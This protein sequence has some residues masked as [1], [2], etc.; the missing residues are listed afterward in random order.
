MN[1]FFRFSEHKVFPFIHLS[2]K[3]W[4]PLLAL[5][6][7]NTLAKAQGGSTGRISGRI[8]D[9]LSGEAV[10][11]GSVGLLIQETNKVVNGTTS[12]DKGIF[13]LG[14]IPY[15]IY[16][17]NIDFIG[18]QPFAKNNIV[19]NAATPN[20]VLGDLRLKS[21]ATLKTVTITTEHSL[22]ENKIDKMVY[23]ADKDLTAQGGVATDLLKK[24]PQIS[25]DVDGN[26]ELQGN[27]NITFLIDGKPSTV[28]GNNVAD[29]LA[30]IPSS[31][32][33]AIE[34]VTSPGAK[35]DA[36]GTGGIINIVLKKSDIQ[37][38]N[39][40]LSLS[41][42]TRLENGSFNL[43]ARKGKFGAH[44]YISGNAQLLST[45]PNSMNRLS[46]DSGLQSSRLIQNGSSDFMR[47]GVQSGLSFDWAINKKNNLTASMSYNFNNTSNTGTTNRQSLLFDGAG[48][49][50]SNTTDIIG[51]NSTFHQ[52]VYDYSLSYK[53]KF[54]KEGQELELLYNSSYGNSFNYYKQLQSHQPL[55]DL[56]NGSYGNN[57]SLTSQ[58]NIALNYTQPL[59]SNL[60]LE[61]GLKTVIDQINS[62]SDV[63]LLNT[64][65]GNYD[66]SSSQSSSV[67][68]NRNVYAAYAS[69]T[70]KLFKY[71]DLKAGCR[72]EYT[73]SK[74][75][76]ANV[77]N[78]NLNPYGTVV[79]SAIIAHNFN[80]N[81]SLKLGYSYRI[82]R[83]NYRDLNPFM[84]ASDPKNITTGNPAL[85][86]ETTNKIELTYSK[87]YEKGTNF[88]IVL[89]AR[90]NSNDIQSYTRYYTTYKIG[91]ST[92]SNVAITNR[93]NIGHE[94]N[95]GAN[96]FVSVPIG[97]KFTLRCNLS[98]FERFIVTGLPT[99]GNITG[100]NYRING[101]ATYQ[102][103]SGLTL[104]VFGN[105]NSL[106]VNAQGTL[107]SFSSY[108]L[109]LRQ[110]LFHKKGSIALVATNPFN[111]YVNQTSTLNGEN[112]SLVS[113]RE[114]PYR[115]FG[116]NFMYK[117]G[118]LEFKKTKET[119]DPNAPPSDN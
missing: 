9:S 70:T 85:T 61:T 114:L 52:E 95:Y 107:P 12:D 50:L 29:V 62:N 2:K 115:S 7:M 63:F 67:N 42:G 24:I 6:C 71:L 53:K 89:F 8:I 81:Q 74:A 108:N 80:N 36:E 73:D 91:D 37:G 22:I 118:K 64:G 106:Y 49:T 54:I 92:Y 94:N 26:V 46:Q 21:R 77:G 104:E 11:Y 31:Q 34:V 110:Q 51:T 87:S 97:S 83:P 35:Y 58:T 109:A 90:M 19:V 30:T 10:E 105:F 88:N 15:G 18:Y 84:N 44:A 38:I 13:T 82:Q 28:F 20:I 72:Y 45:T 60:T 39:G 103:N 93:E 48:N 113:T 101:T 1:A 32:I 27:S 111:E 75:I 17:I 16:K 98:A 25:V 4:L 116:I 66:Y 76:F 3:I 14:G 102:V 33:Q 69:V 100:F 5:L 43:N 47:N 117:F 99:G 112:F 41:G 119:E 65:T 57:P 56:F 86:P 55:D 59:D 78:V 79:P 23:N 96:A 40:S 68:Y